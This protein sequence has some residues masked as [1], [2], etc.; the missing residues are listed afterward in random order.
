MR[1][2]SIETLREERRRQGTVEQ[3]VS[4]IA[5]DGRVRTVAK[6]IVNGE[7]Q[8]PRLAR[9]IGEM[10]TTPAGL[11]DVVQKSVLDLELGREAVP[12]LWQPIYQVREDPNFTE[13]VEVTPFVGA[14]VVFLQRMELEEVTFGSRKIGAKDTVPIITY[15]A[16]FEWTE[17]LVLY[18]RTWEITELNRA[19]GEAYNA[20]LNH[21]HLYPILSFSYAAKNKTAA[22][23]TGTY[24]EKLR[25]TI[26]QGLIHAS[27]DKNTDT[28]TPRRPSILLAH[29]SM[30]WDIEQALQRMVI[31]GTE[32][33]PVSAID[34]LIFYDGWS[35]TV[36]ERTYDYP[37]VA[38]NKAYLIDRRRY[39]RSLVKH[40]LRIDAAGADAS[41]LKRLV[42]GTIVARARRGVYTSPANAVEEL[43]LPAA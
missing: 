5:P 23:T 42:E 4:F 16:G 2:V 7:M 3:P 9:P 21:V 41:N 1:V 22:A 14:Q 13:F 35:V 39:F 8:V 11:Y 19:L 29:S 6:R 43:T 31:G 37:G 24:L 27:Q 25:E 36:G 30:R 20:L 33:P 18:D 28:G 26:K 38:T 15:A 40:D 12:Q 32:Y 10:L 17:D 34:T